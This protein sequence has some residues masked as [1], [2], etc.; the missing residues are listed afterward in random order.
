MK[1]V[2]LFFVWLTSIVARAGLPAVVS[3]SYFTY[4]IN[5]PDQKKLADICSQLKTDHLQDIELLHRLHADFKALISNADSRL[6]AE[7]RAQ[8]IYEIKQVTGRIVAASN[9]AWNKEA[10]PF[11][12]VWNLP[13]NLFFDET[14]YKAARQRLNEFDDLI[15]NK[16]QIKDFVYPINPKS[17]INLVSFKSSKIKNDDFLKAASN[18]NEFAS[19]KVLESYYMNQANQDIQQYFVTPW[20]TEDQSGLDLSFEKNVT[21]LEFCQFLPKT[22]FLIKVDYIFEALGL[23]FKS[24]QDFFLEIKMEN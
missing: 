18:P 22:K 4:G 7:A 9:P 23:T 15:R 6:D 20:Y 10:I 19:I 21:A 11:K 16:D 12:I 14:A 5:P 24:D 17:R 8:L 3:Q 1:C 13:R 2:L